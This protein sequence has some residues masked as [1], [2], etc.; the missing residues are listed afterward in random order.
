MSG[1]DFKKDIES[2][3]QRLISRERESAESDLIQLKAA[4]LLASNNTLACM[5]KIAGVRFGL[6]VN[7]RMIPV[8]DAEIEEIEKFL[9]GEPN[10]WE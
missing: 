3:E 8:I 7:D 9:K 6:S 10:N 5:V 1:V 4:R 2:L